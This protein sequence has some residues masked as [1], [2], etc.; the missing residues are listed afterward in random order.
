MINDFITG[1][2]IPEIG[3]EANRQAVE[4][5]L[6]NEKGYAKQDVEVDA[7]IKMTVGA[8][9]YLSRI[10]LVVSVRG[11]R[12]MAIKCAAG[13]LGSWAR[14]IIAAAR[15]IDSYQIPLAVVSDGRNAAVFDVVSGKKIGDGLDSIPSKSQAEKMLKE[16]RLQPFPKDRLEREKLI[17]SSYD[18]MNINRRII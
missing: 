7:E 3:P 15:L 16:T 1:K 8:I 13:S 4:Q 5:L 6:V 12:F 17:F 11:T 9:P 14:E 2:E 18:S 10:D